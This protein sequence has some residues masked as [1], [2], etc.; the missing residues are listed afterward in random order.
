M[1]CNEKIEIRCS[2][3]IVS[4]HCYKFTFIFF[5]VQYNT[6]NTNNFI[7]KNKMEQCD[8]DDKEAVP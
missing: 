1:V 2:L 3:S 4:L 8:K 5:H 7:H 6:N